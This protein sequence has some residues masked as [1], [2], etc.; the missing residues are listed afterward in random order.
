MMNMGYLH[1]F[2]CWFDCLGGTVVAYET[3]VLEVSGSGR[4]K[5][6]FDQQKFVLMYDYFLCINYIRWQK[7]M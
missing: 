4:N 7:E 1:M 2:M 3:A 6:L 5:W